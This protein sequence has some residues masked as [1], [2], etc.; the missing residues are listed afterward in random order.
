MHL[1]L[2][3]YNNYTSLCRRQ[4]YQT[5]KPTYTDT[6]L[7][8]RFQLSLFSIVHL[9]VIT[10]NWSFVNK[11]VGNDVSMFFVHTWFIHLRSTEITFKLWLHRIIRSYRVNN[12]LICLAAVCSLFVSIRKPFVSDTLTAGAMPL[13][14]SSWGKS[15]S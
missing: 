12:H 9:P 8:F 5:V 3:F 14:F 11:S 6:V 15:G 2:I 7:L 10:S 1:S 13:I 4:K